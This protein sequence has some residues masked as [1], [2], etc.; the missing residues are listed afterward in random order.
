MKVQLFVFGALREL[1]ECDCRE[2]DLPDGM[3]AGDLVPYLKSNMAKLSSFSG[4]LLVAVN[5]E[6]ALASRGLL[7]GDEVAIMPPFAGG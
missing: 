7:D 1:L 3:T 4:G 6:H 5:Q 2:L